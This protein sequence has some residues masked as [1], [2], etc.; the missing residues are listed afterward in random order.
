MVG[1]SF[2]GRGTGG[3][4]DVQWKNAHVGRAPDSQDSWG[5]PQQADSSGASIGTGITIH[6]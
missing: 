5:F 6:F 2:R 4:L 3:N 1:L